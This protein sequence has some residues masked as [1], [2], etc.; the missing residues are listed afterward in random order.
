MKS[1]SMSKVLLT[2]LLAGC[3]AFSTVSAQD[4]VKV[5]KADMK[6]EMKEK[7]ADMK[8][9]MKEKKADMKAEVKATK[10]AHHK[11]AKKAE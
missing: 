4:P 3:V 6:A 5:K 1:F 11:K 9:E 8:V 10:K 7:K 2:G